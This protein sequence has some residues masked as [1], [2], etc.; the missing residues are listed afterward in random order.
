MNKSMDDIKIALQKLII[1]ELFDSITNQKIVLKEADHSAKLKEVIITDV[2]DNSIVIKIDYG[3]EQEQNIFRNE[4]GERKRCDYLLIAAPDK[5]NK[6]ILLFVEMK[7]NTFTQ[8]EISQKFKASECLF[9]YII[10]M[11]KRFHDTEIKLDECKKRFVLF[12]TKRLDKRIT[13]PTN[14][15]STPENYLI[16]KF[17]PS[18]PL[19]LERL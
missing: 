16:V 5:S 6:I 18:N 17:D 12:Q 8:D 1:G 7:S 19:K 9:D 3:K 4:K 15:G 14:Y 11:L 13:H 2:P 10:S